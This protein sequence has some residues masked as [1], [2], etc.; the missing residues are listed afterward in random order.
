VGT[1]GDAATFSFYPTKNLGALGDGGAVAVADPALAGRVASL[2]QY[3]WHKHYISD[4]IGVNSRLDE[5][6]AAIL[7]VKLP[8]LDRQNARRAEIASAYDRALRD[9][10]VRPPRARHGATHVYHL[11]VVRTDV[12]DDVQAVLRQK[13]IGTGIHY[14]VPVHQQPAYAGHVALAA[15]GC[16]ETTSAARQILSL[17]L[18]PEL[19]DDQV[20]FICNAVRAL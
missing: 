11:Y 3:G 17:P 18:Y 9:S 13:G 7:R 6:Q 2:R 19:T 4:E 8:H 14:P 12:R 1:F 20:G 16:P 15:S 5:L 10:P